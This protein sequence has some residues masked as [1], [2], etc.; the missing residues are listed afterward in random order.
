MARALAL[1][2]MALGTVSPNPAVGAVV[3]KDGVIVGEGY[4][5]LPGSHHAE[6]MALHKAKERAA[7]A[8]LYVSLEPCC[9]WGRTPPCTRAIIAAGISEVHMAM[10]DPNPLVNGKGRQEV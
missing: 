10:L 2:R 1:A 8:S 3:V 5:Q 7:G 9:H 6:I 4:T